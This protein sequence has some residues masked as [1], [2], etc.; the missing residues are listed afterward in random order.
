MDTR[1]SH[2]LLLRIEGNVDVPMLRNWE[3]DIVTY[4]CSLLDAR[5][6]ALIAA[7]P[8]WRCE[9]IKFAV[10]QVSFGDLPEADE[11]VLNAIPTRLKLPAVQIDQLIAAGRWAVQR[12]AGV[13]RFSA[14]QIRGE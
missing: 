1:Q 9:D 11:A 12:D 4:R 8:D 10:T 13:R 6:A 2:A 7:N 14:A 5:K 3:R